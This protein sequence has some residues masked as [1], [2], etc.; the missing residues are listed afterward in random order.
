M[1]RHQRAD[2]AAAEEAHVAGFLGFH[3]DPGAVLAEIRFDEAARIAVALQAVVAADVEQRRRVFLHRVLLLVVP[4]AQGDPARAHLL[5]HRQRQD[6]FRAV[7][8]IT[9][10]MVGMAVRVQLGIAA[11]VVGEHQDVPGFAAL[12]LMLEVVVDAFALDQAR[13]EFERGLVVLGAILQSRVGFGEVEVEIAVLE[14]VEDDLDD[15]PDGLVL[16]D[17]VVLVLG[18]EPEPGDDVAFVGVHVM[19]VGGHGAAGALEAGHVSVPVAHAAIVVGAR[20]LYLEI[21]R[22]ADDL[23]RVDGVAVR[24]Q[25]ELKLEQLRHSFMAGHFLDQQVVFLVLGELEAERAEIGGEVGRHVRSPLSCL[26][27]LVA[28]LR[29]IRPKCYPRRMRAAADSAK[30]LVPKGV[31]T[32]VQAT[33]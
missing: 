10:V 12:D 21:R 22:L 8:A 33:W 13:N 20:G 7:L 2:L 4:V 17:A 29:D 27:S 11:V 24:P 5:V 1:A 16:E 9:G 30:G 31:G 26:S 25:P 32:G 18:H 28:Q 14:F 19:A 23:A 3:D 6:R 15:F